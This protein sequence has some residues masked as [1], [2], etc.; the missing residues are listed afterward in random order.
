MENGFLSIGASI[1]RNPDVNLTVLTSVEL[2]FEL[3]GT[4]LRTL[5]YLNQFK[6]MLISIAK[7]LG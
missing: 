4:L 2:V 7:G 1:T 3:G 6:N 5:S